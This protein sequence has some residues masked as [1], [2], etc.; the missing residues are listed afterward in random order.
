MVRVM[1]GVKV[2]ATV[3]SD[4]NWPGLSFDLGRASPDFRHNH[5]KRDL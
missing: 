1:V 4:F 2:R 5:K 3:S